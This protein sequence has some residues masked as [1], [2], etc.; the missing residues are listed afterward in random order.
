VP[1]VESADVERI[2][3]AEYGR[4]VAI[5]IRQL[6]DIDA[7]Q[8]AVQDA[9]AVALERW[10]QDGLPPSPAGWIITAARNRAIDRARRE[11]TRDARHA[12]A[13]RLVQLAVR[14]EPEEN[15]VIDDRLRLFFTC[16]HPA[17][18]VEARVA[19]TLRLVGGLTT[20]EI[21]RAFL[22]SEQTMAQRLVRAKGKIRDAGIPYRVPERPELPRRLPAVLAAIYLIF[23]EGYS[24]SAGERPVRADLIAEAIRLGRIVVELLPN[25]NEALGLLALMLLIDARRAARLDAADQLILLRDQDRSAW[26]ARLIAEGQ[27]IVRTCL[28]RNSPGPYQIQAAIQAVHSDA[29]SIVETDWRQILTLYDQLLSC[30][31]SA[32]VRLNRAVALAEIDG[33]AAGLREIEALDLGSYYLFHAVRADFLA[34]LGRDRE[35]VAAFDAALALGPNAGERAII[36]SKRQTIRTGP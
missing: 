17:L 33:P 30:T 10:P 23:N 4:A 24:S 29:S 7:A 12:E 5:L 9:F 34:R 14:E 28:A 15:T 36:Q 8:E 32:V 35:A 13:V 22:V 21:A 31:P 6:R 19:L 18:A 25:E 20:G 26:D 2:F 16:C 3:R 27:A 1:L 11:S